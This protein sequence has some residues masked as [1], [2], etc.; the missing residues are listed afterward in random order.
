LITFSGEIKDMI[1]YRCVG[2]SGILLKV[3]YDFTILDFGK[4][5]ARHFIM[6]SRH[7]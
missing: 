5:F 7:T 2:I 3:I 6:L 1:A 4:N